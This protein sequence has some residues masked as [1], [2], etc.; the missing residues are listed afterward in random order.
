MPSPALF[1]LG[2]APDG[3]IAVGFATGWD[4]NGG[5]RYRRKYCAMVNVLRAVVAFAEDSAVSRQAHRKFDD[6]PRSGRRYGRGKGTP[7][8]VEA[9][10]HSN[11]QPRRLRSDDRNDVLRCRLSVARAKPPVVKGGG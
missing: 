9:N 6:W 10:R 2:A 1:A 4:G 7:F 5:R 8:T 11:H 3:R